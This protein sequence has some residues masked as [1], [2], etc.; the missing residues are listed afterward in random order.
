MKL[1]RKFLL[2]ILA[3]SLLPL[4]AYAL[5]TYNRYETVLNWQ[6]EQSAEN[7]MAITSSYAN[8]ALQTINHIT[9]AMYLPDSQQLSM[10]DDLKKFQKEQS[11]YAIILDN[12]R[13]KSTYESYFYNYDY[14][15]GIF[16]VTP[17]GQVLGYSSG[18]TFRSDH[19]ATGAAWYEETVNQKGK[20][21]IYGPSKK[22]FLTEDELSISFSTALYDT[23]T[24][25]FLGGLFVDCSPEIFDLS[26]VN[27]LPD[28]T[29]LSVTY[30][31]QTLYQDEA[32]VSEEFSYEDALTY[33]Q[34][35]ALEG[36]KLHA[37]IDRELLVRQIGITQIT[38]I[39]L[40][41]ICIFVIVIVATLFSRSLT[42]PITY[43]SEQ[44][45]LADDT[46][47]I[48]N[49]PYFQYNNEIGTLYNSYQQMMDERRE[50]IKNELENKLILLD[51]Q[52][53]ALESQ[54]NAHFLYN[55][56]DSVSSLALKYKADEISIMAYALGDMFRYSI[57]TKSE[58]VP[59][60]DELKHVTDYVSI[61]E[62]RFD[63]RFTLE[64]NIP[65]RLKEKK[66]L[67][68]ILQ[69]LVENALYHGL[70]YCR[71]GDHIIVSAEQRQGDLLLTVQD[72]GQGMGE[73]QLA[74]LHRMIREKPSFTELGR[75]QEESIGIKNIHTRI[76]LYY[77]E[78]YGLQISSRAGQGT[79]VLIVIPL[80]E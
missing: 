57:K 34:D 26:P 30:E 70:Q 23:D 15:N 9:E 62:I 45:L 8:N 38:L 71:L 56:L 59:L 27:P 54:I 78:Y 18:T 35:L 49:T 39:I 16:V 37:Y 4:I 77:G 69:P 36:L 33:T 28:I 73:E 44:M 68:L 10:T 80:L 32:L 58:L 66:V 55:T 21:C 40:A 2:I 11:A 48:Q 52:M 14:I 13:M 31:G 63:H 79:V 51:S 43:L 25:T 3:V 53:K 72:N 20:T 6:T 61:Q 67:K 76:H 75:R 7:L 41:S 64:M 24:R 46:Q 74:K 65:E 17:L 1:Q 60:S 47:D 5:Y 19:K 50:Y 42:K 12:Q 29:V 22:E